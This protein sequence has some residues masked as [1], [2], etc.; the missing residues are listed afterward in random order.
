ML[1]RS[2]L[3]MPAH[4][5]VDIKHVHQLAR[6]LDP[7]ELARL[8]VLV[9]PIHALHQAPPHQQLDKGAQALLLWLACSKRDSRSHLLLAASEGALTLLLWLACSKRD[10]RHFHA[11]LIYGCR[12]RR[13]R[14]SQATVAICLQVK[15]PRHA[16]SGSTVARSLLGIIH[17]WLQ[18]TAPWCSPSGWPLEPG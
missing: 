18:V 15:V 14:P 3:H 11:A 17:C 9:A 7:F 1:C 12:K 8:G 2:S 5:E 4:L 16:S 6:P 10:T 13:N